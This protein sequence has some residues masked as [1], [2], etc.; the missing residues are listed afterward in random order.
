MVYEITCPGWT[1]PVTTAAVVPRVKLMTSGRCVGVTMGRGVWVGGMGVGVI[2]GTVG[3]GMGG[4][5]VEVGVGRT[6]N[7]KVQPTRSMPDTISETKM[8]QSLTGEF[9]RLT[10]IFKPLSESIKFKSYHKTKRG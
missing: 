3:V 7:G 8:D 4:M 1:V 5:G 6:D 2:G 10:T 9:G